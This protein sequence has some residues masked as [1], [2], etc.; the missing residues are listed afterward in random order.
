VTHGTY[1]VNDWYLNG[2]MA[3]KGWIVGYKRITNLTTTNYNTSATYRITNQSN[4]HIRYGAF[5]FPFPQIN[6]TFNLLA[7]AGTNASLL[8]I[9]VCNNTY[10]DSIYGNIPISFDLPSAYPGCAYAG[11]INATEQGVNPENWTWASLEITSA[12]NSITSNMSGAQN[13][14][15]HL[16]STDEFIINPVGWS[17]DSKW[18]PPQFNNTLEAYRMLNS[19]YDFE[20]GGGSGLPSGGGYDPDYNINMS[21]NVGLWKLDEG[22]G[23]T[24]ED[25]SG[26][27]NNGTITGTQYTL[28]LTPAPQNKTIHFN[29]SYGT[30]AYGDDIIVVPHDSSL[31]F[32]TE[33]SVCSWVY[34]SGAEQWQGMVHKGNLSNF[35]NAEYALQMLGNGVQPT[36]VITSS[37]GVDVYPT[38]ASN[39]ELNRWYYLCGTFNSTTVAIWVDGELEDTTANTIGTP[40]QSTG[41][42][43][44]GAQL[45][46]D[47]NTALK[48]LGFN[49]RLDEVAIFNRSLSTQEI[50]QIFHKGSKKLLPDNRTYN[51]SEVDIYQHY[52]LMSDTLG[53]DPSTTY[54]LFDENDDVAQ[55]QNK[56]SF[57]NVKNS[58][59]THCFFL[60]R[61]RL[62]NSDEIL[63][64]AG[65]GLN[66][67][68]I[69]SSGNY[70]V[71]MNVR[72]TGSVGVTTLVSSGNSVGDLD[73]HH[74]CAVRSK[75]DGALALL[76]DGQKVDETPFDNGYMLQDPTQV[77]F[78][79]DLDINGGGN[80]FQGQIAQFFLLNVS[81][82]SADIAEGINNAF[83][84]IAISNEEEPG[85]YAEGQ[86]QNS[87]SILWQEEPDTTPIAYIKLRDLNTNM[88]FNSTGSDSLYH[89]YYYT[90]RAEYATSQ[91]ILGVNFTTLFNATRPGSVSA[92]D[93]K[94]WYVRA[95]TNSSC[96]INSFNWTNTSKTGQYQD[97]FVNWSVNSSTPLISQGLVVCSPSGFCHTYS[98]PGV[99]SIEE[100]YEY[101]THEFYC[102][103]QNDYDAGQYNSSNETFD[104]GC[105]STYDD[106]DGTED[107]L[108]MQDD[109]YVCP[110]FH[111][112]VPKNNSYV[113][114]NNGEQKLFLLGQT[115]V[116]GNNVR[117]GS[118]QW[119][120]LY[121]AYNL[122]DR[123]FD[124][125]GYLTVQNG[126]IA[127]YT[128]KYVNNYTFA[129][130]HFINM[131]IGYDLEHTQA[132]NF[133]VF[134]NTFTGCG[135]DG[136]DAIYVS[137]PNVQ[138]IGN[139][140][141]SPA[142]TQD[143]NVYCD[144]CSNVS[145]EQNY[146]WDI[147]NLEIYTDGTSRTASTPVGNITCTV[148][149]FGTQYPYANYSL[150]NG[151]N[152][153]NGADLYG[154][155]IDWYPC[156]TKEYS[157][158]QVISSAGTYAL[159]QNAVG[160]PND[161]TEVGDI[162]WACI[163]IA[164][165]N[166]DFS[167]NGF[168]I[169]NNGTLDA[170]AIL[171]NGSDSQNY[172]NVTIRDC[173]SISLYEKGAYI[174]NSTQDTIQNVSAHN[175]TEAG[176][177]LSGSSNNTLTNNSATNNGINGFY[178][179][180]DSPDNDLASNIV[181]SNV[182]QD[183]YSLNG[184]NFGTL[185]TCDSWNSWSEFSHPGC[186][187]RC[188]DVWQYFYGDVDGDILLAP[189]QTD[190]FY[191]W[192]WN[193]D[194][195]AIYA[196]SENA[197]I[198]W[199]SLIALGRNTTQQNSTNDFTEL[200]TLLGITTE[201]DNINDTYSYDGS[202]PKQTENATLFG[203]FV[204]YLP[205][206]NSTVFNN[207]FNTGIAW[208]SSQ[209]G[210][211]FNTVDD[212]DVVFA[213]EIN[214][215]STYDYE[216]RVPETFATYKGGTTVEFWVELD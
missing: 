205:I 50:Q 95:V 34:V 156:T 41:S 67:R 20:E 58:S 77:L 148:G 159:S 31:N 121:W 65:T 194:A 8:R 151:T 152:Y 37:S 135:I 179:T 133:Y 140:F 38:G 146:Y 36:F 96:T 32:N 198:D 150:L 7:K 98:S 170:A 137:G 53:F 94:Y 59:F 143:T 16:S 42:L 145:L 167:C 27:G 188:T 206:A 26:N 197:T 172:T 136:E 171:I 138:I 12:F 212:Q 72:R 61:D 139:N 117:Y 3:E 19:T 169:T 181:C 48:K 78:G 107:P 30:G 190:I 192:N 160:A 164:S 6:Q 123:L 163:K 40:R 216:I 173:P 55:F 79:R 60:K 118:G 161:A 176:I 92:N 21:G 147:G 4:A 142:A 68:L 202:N 84:E 9:Y 193:G 182:A 83:W 183:L 101:G 14:S 189:T 209:G 124:A 175:N 195:G 45:T 155:I 64:S 17:I 57:V 1:D 108:I 56:T 104:V 90:N 74:V 18:L 154:E 119:G 196:I 211:Q 130:V 35:N 112:A 131:S 122:S 22:S 69:N 29:N 15:I 110:G 115:T 114:V 52:I 213:S 208:D 185:D 109:V 28:G 162:S 125:Q 39:L 128:D 120:S 11:A 73:W 153:T 210:S 89:T 129:G 70:E 46:Q 81:V 200:D 180:A 214:G 126:E 99:V 111:T 23:T 44:I 207:G 201:P 33:G 168:N 158:C 63:Y 10:S 25:V 132:S 141:S 24:I 113:L 215:S 93:T 82:S 100:N 85:V 166:V 174:Y 97:W 178:F 102:F 66:L 54:V 187:F 105:W 134:N 5:F 199:V 184:T 191:S 165:S 80:N 144:G 2:I 106:Y 87:T 91:G 127:F 13:Y 186:T 157:S 43:Q 116:D 103:S 177:R 47:Y 204:P 149:T 51:L 75:T 76:V 203:H 71:Q 62:S 49:G 88:S 86:I